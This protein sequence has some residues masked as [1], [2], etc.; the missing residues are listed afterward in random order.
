MP[1]RLMTLL[2]FAM[3]LAANAGDN[4]AI[5]AEIGELE[6]KIADIDRRS[7][8]LE[9][10]VAPGRDSLQAGQALN[11]YQD[12]VY[13]HLIGDFERSAE[14]FF[15]LVTTE[16]MRPA[17]LHWDAEWYLAES[18]FNMGASEI[19]EGTYQ[20]ISA[21][22]NHPFREEAV[23]RLLEIYSTDS[24]P[25]KFDRLYE[26]E[27]L[28]GGVKPS[29]VILYAVAKAFLTKGRVA[30]ATEYF[31]TI[32]AGSPYYTKARYYLGAMLVDRK[33][34]ES[35]RGAVVH[36]Q[37]VVDTPFA[38]QDQ[39]QVYDLAL[40]AM[41]RIHYEFEEYSK[42]AMAYDRIGGDSAFFDDKLYELVW[43]FIKQGENDNAIISID[44][45]LLDFP[46]H[47]LAAEL[48]LV[49]GHLHY[50]EKQYDDALAT[51]S[52]VADEYMP[53]SRRFGELARSGGDQTEWFEQVLNMDQTDLYAPRND[54]ELPAYAVSMMLADPSF[55]SALDLY[56]DLRRQEAAVEVSEKL[57]EELDAA[58]GDPVSSDTIA[59]MRMDA[60]SGQVEALAQLTELLDVEARWLERA[61]GGAVSGELGVFERRRQEILSKVRALESRLEKGRGELSG[62][63]SA[64]ARRSE[65]RA[66]LGA[67]LEAA[68]ERMK[69]AAE[70]N[71]TPALMEV[72]GE[73]ARIERE[74][75]ELDASSASGDTIVARIEGDVLTRLA[76]V[77][78][79]VSSLWQDYQR[80]RTPAGIDA[81]MDPLGARVDAVHI[82]ADQVL[83]RLR[84]VQDQMSDMGNAELT[85]IR[86]TFAQE[87]TNV[88]AEREQLDGIEGDASGIAEQ[89][90]R[91]NFLRLENIFEESV[92]GADMGMVNV[93]WSQWVA[94]GE[95]R[96]R[97][98]DDRDTFLKE[99]E[100]R[101]A[102]LKQKL[103]Q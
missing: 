66:T 86:E 53:V 101:F 12:A 97:L 39:R 51:Y 72:A 17:G 75:G 42:A 96:R 94:T 82:L 43:T 78:L 50:E 31:S 34:E 85:R 41:A 20:T 64:A 44:T 29:D 91:D 26:R 5:E 6:S 19:A 24:D 80:L 15:A 10:Q 7:R 83:G 92:L 102:Y 63:A 76:E 13:H 18:L 46:E 67:D 93:H 56:R 81:D 57:I 61:G 25:T 70:A 95:R 49:R 9:Q 1:R 48:R 14:E 88:R 99:L 65:R 36:F 89:L 74:L 60:L 98:A 32:E 54:D 28:R 8:V 52:E 35:M 58:L 77:E 71:D 37:E 2:L 30:K 16:A 27:I 69:V 23:R 90:V 40:L 73:V 21:D 79:D 59:G 103:N 33:D 100:R 38:T 22:K 68:Q 4:S 84:S 11:R 87:V 47:A 45:F 3:P 55:S 62:V